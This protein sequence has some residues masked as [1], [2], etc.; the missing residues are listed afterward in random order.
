MR[1]AGRGLSLNLN[2]EVDQKPRRVVIL[3]EAKDLC[4]FACFSD[5]RATA[6]ILRCAQDDRGSGDDSAS[7][8]GW[9]L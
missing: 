3:S 4:S 5:L 8:F 7:E 9:N 6:E 2:S 1:R